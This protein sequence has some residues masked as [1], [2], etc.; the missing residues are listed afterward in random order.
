METKEYE[1]S[2]M[3]LK[4]GEVITDPTKFQEIDTR[5]K[6]AIAEIEESRRN[7]NAR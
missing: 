7:R 6:A 2:A 3:N 5:Y 4:F 1:N